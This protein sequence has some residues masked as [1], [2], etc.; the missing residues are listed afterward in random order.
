MHQVGGD[1]SAFF[2]PRRQRSLGSHHLESR[3]L[4]RFRRHVWSRFPRPVRQAILA[5]LLADRQG[6]VA[7]GAAAAEPVSVVGLLSTATG[8]GEG[9]RL[10]GRALA[11]LGYDVRGVDVSPLL[12]G[13]PHPERRAPRLEPGRG[14]AIL[15]FNP[16][17]LPAI[18]TL[19]GRGRLRG[20][21][22][23]GYW[24]WEL[25]RIPGRWLPA[26]AE[27]DE[28]WTPTRFV[29]DAV[30]PFTDKPVRVVPHPVALGRVG[31]R[32]RGDFG[33]EGRFVALA[34]FSFASSAP[35]KNPVAAVEAFRRA[36]GDDPGR[37]LV[38]KVSDGGDHPEDM[39]ELEA[40]IA[41]A[42]NV[43][44]EE[45]R[46]GEQDRL[47]LIASADAL[48]S[49]HRSEGFGLVMA[50]AML[51]GVPVVATGW[52]GNMDFMDETSAL[53]VPF[54]MVEAA[55]RNGVY[56]QNE[57]WADP[58]VDAAAEHLRALAERPAGFE[59]M[60]T[61]ARAMAQ[62]RLGLE[63]ARRLIGDAIAVPAAAASAGARR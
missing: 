23:V 62:E 12:S 16:D 30:R 43:R 17:H 57:H 37:L 20:K 44:I 26:L 47:D 36:F 32:R 41:G 48:L 31:T 38:L 1:G 51:A 34:M 58:D 19:L 22:I 14:T 53:L 13:A 40:A 5:R 9:G 35:R 2:E 61:A 42:A 59:A 10:A 29:A 60:R 49:L 52:S 27:V 39:A 6:P 33:F 24:A 55:D 8:I 25:P 3:W 4:Q 18:I 7:V 15:H 28:I 11:A 21:R 63:A 54:R 50:E 45:R 56:G 46:F